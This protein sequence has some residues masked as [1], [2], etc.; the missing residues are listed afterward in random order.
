[1][2]KKI[3]STTLLCILVILGAFVAFNKLYLSKKSESTFNDEFINVDTASVTQV[4]IYPKGGKEKEIKINKQAKGWELEC[5]KLKTPADTAAVHRL[6]ASF[7]SIRSNGLA[8]ADK[9]SWKELQVDD[10]SGTR[11][12]I[13]AGEI[14]RAHV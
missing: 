2:F 1:M 4:V 12:K 10:S 5:D 9:S 3:N 6:I 7:A 11:V 14:G 8:G 13:I